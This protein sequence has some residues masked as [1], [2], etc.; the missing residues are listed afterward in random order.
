MGASYQKD[1]NECMRIVERIYKKYSISPVAPRPKQIEFTPSER[2]I[3]ETIRVFSTLGT[4]QGDEMFRYY[5][6]LTA[7]CSV[8][9]S[10]R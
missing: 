7:S 1:I 8:V 4:V 9:S 2:E 3:L 10:Q 5:R 6:A